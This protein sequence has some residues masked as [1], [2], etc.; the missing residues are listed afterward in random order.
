MQPFYQDVFGW[1]FK[2]L[3]SGPVEYWVVTM[4]D[5]KDPGIDG[6]LTRP[7]EGQTTGRLNGVAIPSLD[8]T[9]KKIEQRGGRICVPKM[10]I[11][12]VGGL[13]YAEDPAGN[14]SGIMES[15]TNTK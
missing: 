6:E 11:L 1:K 8:A 12:G 3:E 14:V 2:K 7:R 15:D 5:E 10:A 4:G 13:A 9:M